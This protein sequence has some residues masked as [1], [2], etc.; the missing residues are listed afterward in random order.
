MSA[1][2]ACVR[3]ALSLAALAIAACGGV[4]PR[5]LETGAPVETSG[6]EPMPGEPGDAYDDELAQA[7]AELARALPGTSETTE[8]H[9]GEAEELAGG[10]GAP[11]CD[12]APGLRDRIC[13]LADRI[14]ALTEDDPDDASIAERCERANASCERA[15]RDV[16]RAC[17]Q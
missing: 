13:E 14:C 1:R 11:D 9:E 2:A 5:E 3:S 17:P 15:R 4:P 12:A 7:E 10:A 8:A 16:A 6:S